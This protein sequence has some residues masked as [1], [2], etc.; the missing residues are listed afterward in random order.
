MGWQPPARLPVHCAAFDMN[1]AG[2]D[3][4]SEAA[5]FK[6]VFRMFVFPCRALVLMVVALCV[7][8]LSLA[9]SASA[10]APAPI[11][12][13]MIEALSG[14]FAN[15]GEAVFRNLIWAV[16]RVNGRGGVKLA[17]S[18]ESPGGKRPLALERYDSKGQ[19]EEALT[20]LKSAIDDGAQFIMQG[21]S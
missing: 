1:P 4:V 12:I 15:T 2:T 20:A 3:S 16:E 9:Q 13:A 14:P 18:A 8:A 21:N 10:P 6:R 19:N 17:V 11:K 7:P 5:V